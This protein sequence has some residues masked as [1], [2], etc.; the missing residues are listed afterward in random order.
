MTHIR[1]TNFGII[2]YFGQICSILTHFRSGRHFPGKI[3]KNRLYR[4]IYRI[5]LHFLVWHIFF[6]ICAIWVQIR[7]YQKNAE[8]FCGSFYKDDFCKFYPESV[9]QSE[10]GSKLSIFGPK[11]VFFV[12]SVP[13]VCQIITILKNFVLM[14]P[15][16]IFCY[17]WKFRTTSQKKCIISLLKCPQLLTQAG[18]LTELSTNSW[19]GRNFDGVAIFSNIHNIST[20]ADITHFFQLSS[21]NTRKYWLPYSFT[22]LLGPLVTL[23]TWPSDLVDMAHILKICTNIGCKSEYTKKCRKILWIVL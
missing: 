17:L 1:H 3:Y 8:K 18:F 15:M 10:N 6:K 5:F 11:Y 12:N 23:F 20:H 7:I 19:F 13:D 14:L 21:S 9:F 22:N 2:C 4:T 16:R